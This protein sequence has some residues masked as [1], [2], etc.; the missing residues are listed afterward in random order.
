MHQGAQAMQAVKPRQTKVD[1]HNGHWRINLESA[2]SLCERGALAELHRTEM[3]A[4]YTNQ[5]RTLERMGISY[6]EACNVLYHSVAPNSTRHERK[7]TPQEH[8][9]PI[10][11]NGKQT[12][13]EHFQTVNRTGR[14]HR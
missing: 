14:A 7:P 8:R 6:K 3:I 2:F 1:C 9:R 10:F 13:G 4:N 11:V 5:A 12:V